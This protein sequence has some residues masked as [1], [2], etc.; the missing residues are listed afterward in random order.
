MGAWVGPIGF[1]LVVRTGTRVSNVREYVTPRK[2]HQSRSHLGAPLEKCP[3]TT[4]DA[5]THLLKDATL[6]FA[7]LNLVGPHGCPQLSV[8]LYY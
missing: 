7:L 2:Q 8:A 1:K 3:V 5:H 6:S 4:Q